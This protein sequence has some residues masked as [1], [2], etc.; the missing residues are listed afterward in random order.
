MCGG[1]GS[2]KEFSSRAGY[3]IGPAIVLMPEGPNAY[4]NVQGRIWKVS[5]EHLRLH[6]NLRSDTR[7]RGRARGLPGVPV[8]DDVV[9]RTGLNAEPNVEEEGAARGAPR[10]RLDEPEVP[11]PPPPIPI[12][13]EPEEPAD[14]VPEPPVP[15][16]PVQENA[17]GQGQHPRQT[18]ISSE[19]EREVAPQASGST[20]AQHQPDAQSCT[21]NV[22]T[23]TR[24]SRAKR[25][26]F[27]QSTASSN[28]V[29]LQK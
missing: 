21:T 26:T 2:R 4:V 11:F 6:G 8:P 19:P 16:L 29:S 1:R 5:N 18:S 28:G 13:V 3:T 24:S 20:D 17:E 15:L 14:V 25:A 23:T 12:A 7:H 22:F 10:P 9:R 27:F